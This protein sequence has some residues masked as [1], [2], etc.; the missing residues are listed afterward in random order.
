VNEKRQ[1]PRAPILTQVEAQGDSATALGH[2]RDISL[3]GMLIESPETLTEGATVIVR[4]FMPPDRKPIQAAGRIVRVRERKSMGISFMGLRETD[5]KRVADY[6]KGIQ[7]VSEEPLALQPEPSTKGHRRS[8]RMHRRVPVQLSWQDEEGRAQQEAGETQLLSKHGALLLT[9]SELQPGQLMRLV[10]PE[11]RNAVARVVW[12]KPAQMVGRM[13]VG[14]E[15]L[16]SEDFWGIEFVAHRAAYAGKRDRRRS[17]RLPQKIPVVLSW[18]DEHG[19]H[20]EEG[21]ETVLLSQHGTLLKT[22][23]D[24]PVEHRLRLRVPETKSEAEAEVIWVQKGEA[25][26]GVELGIEFV[27][28]EN[29]WEIDFPADDDRSPT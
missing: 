28:A 27:E 17:P 3:G 18:T 5:Q 25:P 23:V 11:G 9:F 2:A 8:A 20:R 12:V 10:A 22:P 4:F 24:L 29:F 1:T 16:G 21:A 15:I 6:I 14:I 13:E 19:R 7:Q 26:G